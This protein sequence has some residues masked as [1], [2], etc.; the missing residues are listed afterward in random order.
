[1]CCSRETCQKGVC[2]AM[3]CNVLQCIVVC[4]S[5]FQFVAVCSTA[6]N[7]DEFNDVPQECVLQCAAVRCSV[8]VPQIFFWL[9]IRSCEWK[10]QENNG[11]T[12]ESSHDV[13]KE[14]TL[15]V[16]KW[17]EM[18]SKFVRRCSVLQCVAKYCSMLPCATEC[19]NVLQCAAMCCNVLQCVAVCCGVLPRDA[20]CCNLLQREWVT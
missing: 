5:V 14:S 8:V 13:W 17:I 16:K 18:G 11:F 3:C 7:R 20:V 2:I 15:I 9:D 19:C 1:M 10:T 4:C 6:T 12:V